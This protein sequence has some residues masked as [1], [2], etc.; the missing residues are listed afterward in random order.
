MHAVPTTPTNKTHFPQTSVVV[1]YLYVPNVDTVT[2]TYEECRTSLI[3]YSVVCTTSVKLTGETLRILPIPQLFA[4][5]SCGFL[6]SISVNRIA[7]KLSQT[8]RWRFHLLEFI[9]YHSLHST[10]HPNSAPLQLYI[11]WRIW[12]STWYI[13]TVANIVH[14]HAGINTHDTRM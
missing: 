6:R 9:F 4:S 8:I 11:S 3:L 12:R 2:I 1:V 13:H 5:R 14:L 10:H 7:F